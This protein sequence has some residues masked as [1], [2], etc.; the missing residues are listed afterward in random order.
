MMPSVPARDDCPSRL[1]GRVPVLAVLLLVAASVAA[2]QT[3]GRQ[4]AAPG[5]KLSP[6]NFKVF[7]S[8]QPLE[9]AYRFTDPV[10]GKAQVLDLK[11]AP[12]DQQGLVGVIREGGREILSLTPKKEGLGYEGFVLGLLR[13]CGQ[14]KVKISD[15]LPLGGKI[16]VRMEARPPETP[17]P[18][19]E[20]R[21][22]A[23]LV[24]APAP[25]PVHLRNAKEIVT[26]EVREQIGLGGQPHGPSTPIL[27]D[28]VSVDGGTEMK[29][30][31]RTRGLDGTIWIEV[32]AIVSPAPGIEPPRGFLRPDE[33]NV[34]ATLTLE[35]IEETGG[36]PDGS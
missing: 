26:D 7:R 9:G 32:E 3:T 27:A 33:L 13:S 29:Y 18:F 36:A 19:L 21:S 20:D 12:G 16:I 14:D 2:A 10:S 15:L 30:V 11:D 35:R 34:D 25:R 23:H 6:L 31:G 4:P 28:A 22:K 5:K 1:S 24:V 17:C 8:D